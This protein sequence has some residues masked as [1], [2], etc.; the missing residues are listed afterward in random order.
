MRKLLIIIWVVIGFMELVNAQKLRVATYNV[1]FENI[2]DVKKGN[3]W[4]QRCPIISQLI[5]FHDFDIFGAQEVRYKQLNDLLER[6]DGYSFVGVGRTDGKTGG[7]YSPIFYKPQLFELLD[8]GTFWLSTTPHV[9]SIGWDAALPRICSWGKFKIKGTAKVFWFFNLHMDHIG[10]QARLESTKLIISKINTMCVNEPV[11]L[12]G[13]FNL[14]QNS[15]GY[16]LIGN[17][18][19]LHDSFAVSEL[20]YALNGTTNA[21]NPNRKTDTRIDHIFLSNDFVTYRYGI[22]TDTYRTA[23]NDSTQNIKPDS[24]YKYAPIGQYEIRLPSDHYPVLVEVGF[25]Y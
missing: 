24:L 15:E 23:I 20:C 11:I 4:E 10:E 22:L 14:N 16:K 12:T 18:T 21:F 17:L 9:P 5:R 7:E 13:D 6:L 25:K 2:G 1:R 3:G 19:K 8:S